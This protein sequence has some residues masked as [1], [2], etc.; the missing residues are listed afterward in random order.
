MEIKH[1]FWIRRVS[2]LTGF[3]KIME[4][5]ISLKLK[6]HIGMW[7]TLTSAQYGFWDGV[8]TSNAIY[9]LINPVYEAWNNKH[10]L[11]CIFWDTTKAS[12]CASH[13]VLLSKLENY[14]VMG[15]VLNWF[16]SFLNDRR[17]TVSLEYTATHCFQS[18]W[19]SMTCGDP[20][21]ILGPMLIYK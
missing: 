2:L 18:A 4:I 9:K 17:Q 5:V 13:E 14:G 16:R 7:N 15:I 19:E 12:D 1:K 11:A 20:Q 6:Q 21:S 10:Y 3:S 8:S